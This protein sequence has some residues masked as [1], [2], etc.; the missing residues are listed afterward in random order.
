MPCA[1][2]TQHARSVFPKALSSET[3]LQLACLDFYINPS[4]RHQSFLITVLTSSTK[5]ENARID[6]VEERRRNL[7]YR[8]IPT[9]KLCVVSSS[10]FQQ[11]RNLCIPVASNKTLSTRSDVNSRCVRR[12]TLSRHYRGKDTETRNVWDRLIVIITVT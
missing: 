12:C 5:N 3:C 10:R 4:L 6:V 2:H 8:K 11:L 7:A 9:R 1:L